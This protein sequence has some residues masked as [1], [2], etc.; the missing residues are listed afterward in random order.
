MR[1]QRRLNVVLLVLLLGLAPL[2]ASCSPLGDDEG[3]ATPTAAAAQ[4]PAAEAQETPADGAGETPTETAAGD[5]T[6]EGT[7]DA[8]PGDTPDADETP[9]GTTEEQ[10]PGETPAGLPGAPGTTPGTEDLLAVGEDIYANVCA[11]CHQPQGEGIDGIY[12]ALAG[13]PLVTLEDPQPVTQ[14]VLAGRGGMPRF[15]DAY[16]DEQIAGIVSYIRT[17]WGN[18]ASEVDPATVAE[19]RASTED[20]PE[21]EGRTGGE[22]T[23]SPD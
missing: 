7:P 11:A 23:D 1:T 9:E 21:D 12:P 15:A 10:E 18:A 14:V 8:G 3:D 6:P 4:S 16:T 2:A 19:I 13:N 17:A 20:V 5:E 22:Q